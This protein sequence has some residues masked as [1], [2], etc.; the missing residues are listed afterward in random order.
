MMD[1]FYA[2][3]YTYTCTNVWFHCQKVASYAR[4]NSGQHET[5]KANN[6]VL[7]EGTGLQVEYQC[8]PYNHI[9]LA[10]TCAQLNV[11]E[12]TL[13]ACAKSLEFEP[14]KS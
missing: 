2:S 5:T 11:T 14:L 7:T 8:L 6:A 10:H 4:Q 3:I 13:K 1:R 9:A 12:P